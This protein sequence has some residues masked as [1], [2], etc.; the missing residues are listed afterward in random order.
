MMG[1]SYPRHREYVLLARWMS[2]HG[3]SRPRIEGFYWH[4]FACLAHPAKVNSAIRVFDAEPTFI[5]LSIFSVPL[6]Y[7]TA[8]W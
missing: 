2:D 8:V 5:R 4:L 6:T 1:Y 7:R 3:K